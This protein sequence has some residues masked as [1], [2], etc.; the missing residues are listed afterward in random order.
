MGIGNGGFPFFSES[1]VLKANR[2]VKA[3]QLGNSIQL[4]VFRNNDNSSK[5]TRNS[6]KNTTLHDLII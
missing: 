5:K 2:A 3:A 1:Q 6:E 4:K